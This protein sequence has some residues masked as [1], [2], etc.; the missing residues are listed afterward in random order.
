MDFHALTIATTQPAVLA[1]PHGPRA[2]F[3]V[4]DSSATAVSHEAH[5]GHE[6]LHLCITN[7]T[8]EARHEVARALLR[9][10]AGTGACP[11]KT[12][13]VAEPQQRCI[14][15]QGCPCSAHFFDSSAAFCL[16]L[17]MGRMFAPSLAQTESLPARIIRPRP[18]RWASSCTEASMRGD[19]QDVPGRGI[20]EE[21]DLRGRRQGR[22]ELESPPSG[23][24]CSQ[25]YRAC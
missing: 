22:R 24:H 10:R 17:S 19:L 16:I 8:G 18:P 25:R 5:E 13:E 4:P 11:Y 3:L 21:A 20:P 23:E 6:D 14:K 2:Q 15:I 9:A 1:V 12:T 7:G